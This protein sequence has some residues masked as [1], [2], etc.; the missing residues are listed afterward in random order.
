MECCYQSHLRYL[1]C[2][3]SLIVPM[4]TTPD[5]TRPFSVERRLFLCNA[6]TFRMHNLKN[7][8]TGGKIIHWPCKHPQ[9]QPQT[10]PAHT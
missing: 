6:N 3:N 9:P 10:I 1:K 8:C 4:H 7:V 5:F 2:W